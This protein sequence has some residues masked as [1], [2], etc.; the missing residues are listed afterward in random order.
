MWH[1]QMGSFCK[2]GD[3]ATL[4]KTPNVKPCTDER[5]PDGL[6]IGTAVMNG[7]QTDRSA[8]QNIELCI[9]EI[10]RIWPS[11][12]WAELASPLS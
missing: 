7:W 3:L 4:T 5:D 8:V 10:V 6:H 12:K 11:Q 9:V 2:Y 1:I